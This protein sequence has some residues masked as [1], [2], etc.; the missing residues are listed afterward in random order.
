M[1]LDFK[2]Y[3]YIYI[4]VGKMVNELNSWKELLNQMN[5]N[6]FHWISVIYLFNLRDNYHW[7]V[8]N[9]HQMFG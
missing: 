4:I 6:R 2:I 3:I 8:V 9:Q 7:T 1:L 5:N